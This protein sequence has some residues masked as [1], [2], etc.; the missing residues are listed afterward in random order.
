M[1]GFDPSIVERA[2]A[3]SLLSVTAKHGLTKLAKRRREYIGACPHC[4]GCSRFNVNA[5]KGVFLCRGCNAGGS[6]AIDLEI[7][8]TGCSF[9]Q[10]IEALTGERMPSADEARAAAAQRRVQEKA[11]QAGQ[12]GTARWLWSQRER[13]QGSPVERYLKA[14]GYTGTIP[15]TIAFLPA[16]DDYAPAMISAYA[17]PVELDNELRA[18]GGDEV[19]AV[20][21]TRLLEDGSDRRRDAHAK[22]TIGAPLGYPIAIAPITDGLSLCLTEGIEDALAYR[23]AG[24]GAWAAGSSSYIGDELAAIIPP[25]ETLLVKRHPDEASYTAIAKLR[26]LLATWSY[27][28]EVIVREAS[29]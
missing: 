29:S 14:R 5:D 18:P 22:I 16:R 26:A 27:P 3:V 11:T 6:G 17:L 19:F 24:F 23:A 20:H 8:V 13:P 15:A 10:A 1:S 25:V 21:I 9:T 12:V 7:F 2:R 28:P 4:G